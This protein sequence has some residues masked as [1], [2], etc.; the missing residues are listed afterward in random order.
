MPPKPYSKIRR[1]MD[2]LVHS[3]D[4][5]HDRILRA[6]YTED[7][8]RSTSK[9][10]TKN[11][12]EESPLL[13][14]PTISRH[15]KESHHIPSVPKALSDADSPKVSNVP[16]KDVFQQSLFAS[17]RTSIFCAIRDRCRVPHINHNTQ[18]LRPPHLREGQP[19]L[20]LV[21]PPRQATSFR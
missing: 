7:V 5:A 13:T 6:Q 4:R 17:S 19:H 1:Y 8:L 18:H 15:H 14:F 21:L 16:P 10:L 11:I 12:V 2:I 9:C 20:N 3:G